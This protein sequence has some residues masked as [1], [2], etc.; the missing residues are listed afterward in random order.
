[1]KGYYSRRAGQRREADTSTRKEEERE[2]TSK[3]G[4]GAETKIN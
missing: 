2:R 1:M 4:L 3:A